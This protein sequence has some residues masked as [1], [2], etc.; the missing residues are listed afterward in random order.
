VTA[1]HEWTQV[2]DPVLRPALLLLAL[3]LADAALPRS[4]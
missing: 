3:G 4:A 2:V 1:Q